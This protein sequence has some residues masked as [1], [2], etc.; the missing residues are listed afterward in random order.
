M[1]LGLPLRSFQRRYDAVDAISRI[2]VNPFDTPLTKAFQKIV[3]DCVTHGR[4]RILVEPLIKPG[5]FQRRQYSAA[6]I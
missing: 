6:E 1:N 4:L 5:H 3:G 2:P